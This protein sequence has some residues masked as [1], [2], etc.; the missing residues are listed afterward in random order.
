MNGYAP[1]N[2]TRFLDYATE[3]LFM[4]KDGGAYNFIHRMLME[5][6]A[7]MKENGRRS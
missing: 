3:Y 7:Q 2:Y 4:K 6:F 1:W 5:H